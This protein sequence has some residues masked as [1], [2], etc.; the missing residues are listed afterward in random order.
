MRAM[1]YTIV[2]NFLL[3][4]TWSFNEDVQV[5]KWQ[6]EKICNFIQVLK[7]WESIIILS[8]TVQLLL[9]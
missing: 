2:V 3:F 7:R 1:L 8:S 4:N 9:Y 6:T 5:Y